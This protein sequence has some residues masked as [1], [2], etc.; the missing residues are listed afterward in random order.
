MANDEPIPQPSL[1]DYTEVT[2]EKPIE[3]PEDYQ[4]EYS[5]PILIAKAKRKIIRGRIDGN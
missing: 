2:S 5:S 1:P 3:I 4:K